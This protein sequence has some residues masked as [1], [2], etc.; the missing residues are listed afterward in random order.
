MTP[1]EDIY[2]RFLT[3]VTDFNLLSLNDEDLHN[4]MYN[5][6]RSA[7]AKQKVF[8]NSFTFDD[9]NL[10]FNEDLTNTEMEVLA[11][12][13][14]I[15][16][17]EPQVNSATLTMQVFSSSDEKYYSQANHISELRGRLK[18]MKTERRKLVR[19]FQYDRFARNGA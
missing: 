14:A 2:T 16:W 11:V 10:C 5:W 17:L 1:Y 12:G 18:E 7:V 4:M 19:D 3:K 9:D 8:E 13:M 15:E 6:L